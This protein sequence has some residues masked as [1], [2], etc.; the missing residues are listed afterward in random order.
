MPRV[1]LLLGGFA[2]F[3]AVSIL[4]LVA[5]LAGLVDLDRATKGITIPALMLGVVIVLLVGRLRMRTSVLALLLG[6][7]TLSWLGDVTLEFFVVGLGFFLVAHLI[8][9]ALFHTGFR[10]RTSWWSLGL[11]AWF[12]GLLLALW[13][14]L[15]EL[16]PVVMLYGVVLGYM[17]ATSSRG[18]VA[19]VIGG[20]LFVASDSLLAFRLFTPLFQSPLEDTFIMALYLAAQFAL[21]LGFLRTAVPRTPATSAPATTPA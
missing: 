12:A 2:P 11:I 17:A 9:I 13:P 3:I 7:L 18:N 19:T 8:Y 10:R 16:R 1:P 5:K 4:H 20:A 6:A 21:V 15:G 14:Y